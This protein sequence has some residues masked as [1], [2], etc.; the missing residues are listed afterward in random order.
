MNSGGV[1]GAAG[2]VMGLWGVKRGDRRVMTPAGN[3]PHMLHTPNQVQTC[4]YLNKHV[5][6]CHTIAHLGNA[7][8]PCFSGSKVKQQEA[9]ALLLLRFFWPSV[10]LL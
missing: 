8:T 9:G 6:P 2:R 3:I 1:M 4:P 5:R 7:S 10:L